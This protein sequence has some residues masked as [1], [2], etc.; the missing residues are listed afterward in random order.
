[1]AKLTR[2]CLDSGFESFGNKSCI[3]PSIVEKLGLQPY[4]ID[5]KIGLADGST[6][7]LRWEVEARLSFQIPSG[8]LT[9]PVVFEVRPKDSPSDSMILST[10][11]L[12]SL[13]GIHDHRTNPSTFKVTDPTSGELVLLQREDPHVKL[14]LSWYPKKED[15]IGYIFEIIHSPAFLKRGQREGLP[16]VAMRNVCSSRDL[17]ELMGLGLDWITDGVKLKLSRW[18]RELEITEEYQGLLDSSETL[19][20]EQKLLKMQEMLNLIHSGTPSVMWPSG[21][22]QRIQREAQWKTWLDTQGRPAGPTFLEE[23]EQMRKELQQ[24]QGAQD[25]GGMAA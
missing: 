2:C 3:N 21:E 10:G 7:H 25:Q 18:A 23:M 8:L 17:R 6:S 22:W 11:V 12:H 24:E 14:E 9:I 13:G 16:A 20:V 5:R 15:P 1:M 4:R 19:P